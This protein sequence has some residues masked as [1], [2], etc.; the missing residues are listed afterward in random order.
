M[1]FFPHGPLQK[2]VFVVCLCSEFSYTI[3]LPFEFF[4]HGGSISTENCLACYFFVSSIFTISPEKIR[5]ILGLPGCVLLLN[6]RFSSTCNKYARYQLCLL[7][8]N[9]V[10]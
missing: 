8:M 4:L 6:L 9:L 5:L 7:Y 10:F 2:L 1:L 3:E